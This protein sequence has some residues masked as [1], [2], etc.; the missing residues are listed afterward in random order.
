MKA[1]EIK[2]PTLRIQQTQGA[3]SEQGYTYNETGLTYNEID[4]AYGGF[5]GES[6]VIAIVARAENL[7]PQIV[8]S[9][10]VY[11]T[12]P[13]LGESGTPIGLLLALTYP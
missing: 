1:Y 12:P 9:G 10:D 2:P 6:D 3:V 11:T 5:Y 8:A 4:V 13:T 7:Y